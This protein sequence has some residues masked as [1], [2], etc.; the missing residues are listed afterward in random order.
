MSVIDDLQSDYNLSNTQIKKIEAW[1]N[2]DLSKARHLGGG[3]HGD[4]YDVGGNRVFK[5]TDDNTEA[6]A[7]SALITNKHK[8]IVNIYKVGKI[9]SKGVIHSYS[10]Y[11]ILQ[12]RLQ[13]IPN[14]DIY[15]ALEGFFEHHFVEGITTDNIE[16]TNGKYNYESAF[17]D[18]LVNEKLHNTELAKRLTNIMLQ[19]FDGLYFLKQRNIDFY[20]LHSG[21]LMF[22]DKNTPVII[23]L[24]VSYTKNPGNIDVLQEYIRKIII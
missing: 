8:N 14:N 3:A 18:Y 9:R 23:D 2:I 21:N 7:S 20:D 4:A 19:I 6:D 10:T 22:R 15:D 16:R 5:F 17:Q 13:N 1:A 24:G 11:L 12:E